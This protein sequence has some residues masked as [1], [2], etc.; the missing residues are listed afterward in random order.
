MWPI[1]L[2]LV[3]LTIELVSGKK[4]LDVLRIKFRTAKQR[5]VFD[6]FE[7]NNTDSVSANCADHQ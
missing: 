3:C 1:Q 2:L 6:R 4:N 5:S 7:K